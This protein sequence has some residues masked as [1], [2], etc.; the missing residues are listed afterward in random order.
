MGFLCDFRDALKSFVQ[1]G[2][3]IKRISNARIIHKIW[4]KLIKAQIGWKE[5]HAGWSIL[6]KIG[7]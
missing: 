1:S 2:N 7:S 6:L 5:V 3:T 4:F